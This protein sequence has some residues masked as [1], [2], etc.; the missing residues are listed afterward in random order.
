MRFLDKLIL[1]LPHIR[2]LNEAV[3]F[4]FSLTPSSCFMFLSPLSNTSQGP[5]L[6]CYPFPLEPVY[7][8]FHYLHLPYIFISS[9]AT[10]NTI[11]HH[12]I[13]CLTFLGLCCLLRPWLNPALCT[14]P[15]PEPLLGLVPP[16]KLL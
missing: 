8:Q 13:Y 1:S 4:P 14:I 3:S 10:F 16:S 15:I 11:S 9:S 2:V 5:W 12:Y 7:F 6:Y